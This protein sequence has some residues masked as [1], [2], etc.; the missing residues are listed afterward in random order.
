MANQTI[1]AIQV[2]DSNVG[3]GTTSPSNSKTVIVT[4]GTD[5]NEIALALMHGDGSLAVNQE[6]QMNFGQ[7]SNASVALAQIGAAYTGGSFNGALVFRTNS[8]SLIE[9]MRLTS[10]GNV[11]I[12]TDTD[13]GNKLRVQ[14]TT[15]IA[16][17]VFT[18]GEQGIELGWTGSTI[19]DQRIGRIRPIST[20]AQN[21]YA[22]G[23][24]FD[25]YKYDGSS[26]NW[27]EG[28]RLNG[29]GNVGI[30]TA[31]P[32]TKLHIQGTGP[33]L[34]AQ[35][36]DD[37]VPARIVNLSNNVSTVGFQANGSANSFNVRVGCDVDNFVAYTSNSERM[38]ITSGGNVLI[39]TTTD[40][41][42]TLYVN[43]SGL[44]SSNLQTNGVLTIGNQSVAGNYFLSIT[45]STT[46]PVALQG[47]L[48][49]TGA[50][51]ISLQASGGNV[52]IGTTTDNGYKLSVNGAG[53]FNG[54]GYFENRVA[55]NNSFSDANNVRI[56]KP[57][58][59]SRNS[60]TGVETGAI[61]ITY[62]VGYT[63]TM[64]RVKLNIYNYSENQA[65]TVYFGGYNYAPSP[66]WINTFAYTI[67][68]S[69]TDFNPTVRFGY[70]GTK[71]VVYIGELNWTWSYPQFFIEEVE[72][73]FNLES[74]FATDTWSIGLEAS[75]FQNVTATRS[76]TQSTNWARNGSSTYYGF[77]SVGIGTTGPSLESAGIGLDILN[78][79]YTQLRVRS[80][81][82][83]AG[84]E[85]KPSSGDS[86]EIQVNTSQWFVYNRT[87][88]AYRLLIANGGNVLIGTTTDAGY[89]LDVAGTFRASTS[90]SVARIETSTNATEVLQIYNSGGNSGSVQGVTHL[91]IN[92][93]SVGTN[94]PVRITAFQESTSGYRG[95]MYF[96]TRNANSDS[97]PSEA[98]RI[99]PDQLV[100]IGT[101]GT[102]A[103]DYR[104]TVD[105]TGV[106]YAIYSFGSTH[107]DNGALGVGI[108]PSAT[109]GRIDASNDIVAYS[110]S[111]KRLKE[112]ITPIANALD[113]VKAL[114]GVEFDWKPEHKEAHGYEGHDTGVIAQEVK[115][116]MPSAVRENET[117]FLAVRYE[118]LIGLLIEANKELANR[119]EELEKKLK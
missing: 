40:I 26:Y 19:N 117:G 104:L 54:I 28:M 13:N 70:D 60:T 84:I 35:S 7:G 88:E 95:G 30:G 71:M 37:S 8:S 118:K 53:Y 38:R 85:F 66:S 81:S 21:P 99:S 68:P 2:K 51:N 90:G 111:D 15:W 55:S 42:A 31:S 56:L 16:G 106:D 64:H 79:S 107:V 72:T 50:A 22:G 114:T 32:N 17:N 61:K 82:S 91:G 44:F 110:S 9:G 6:V 96:S 43:G 47:V 3:I 116:I 12:G 97:A 101:S 102:T 62:P 119:V 75:A 74:P 11:L 112:N 23:L 18:N 57:L 83:S 39:G 98:M 34:N 87:D 33:V 27:F 36:T 105:S 41:G 46:V 113:K 58:G 78:S 80:S 29:S 5:A 89:K 94:S 14:G 69:G 100:G 103:A 10:G 63:N 20:P 49:G 1:P 76:N 109:T 52:L 93:F 115:E 25:Y 48:A 45:P 65:Y 67:T 73:G 92:F 4:P 24:A 108:V 77:G 86:Y 59:G